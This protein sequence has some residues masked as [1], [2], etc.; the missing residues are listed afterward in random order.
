MT[1]RYGLPYMGSKSKIAR[2]VVERLPEGDTLYDV[3]C[4]RCAI[5]DYAMRARKYKSYVVN[6]ITNIG[7]VFKKA[8]EGGFKNETRWIDRKTYFEEL[9]D[10][11]V[12]LCFSFGNNPVCRYA[13]AV[14]LEPWKKA[15]HWCYVF[16]DPSLMHEYGVDIPVCDDK[17]GYRKWIRNNETYIR[18]R[19]C[20]WVNAHRAE[21]EEK[22]GLKIR[23][24]RLQSLG[25]LER[26]QRLESLDRLQRLQSLENPSSSLHIFQGDYRDVVIP[27]SSG[28]VY[29]D[30]PYHNTASYY[31][32]NRGKKQNL[33]KAF[34]YDGFYAWCEYQSYV[35][36]NPVFVSSYD[37]P[38]SKFRR[39]ASVEKGSSLHCGAV[40]Y[41]DKIEGLYVPKEQDCDLVDYVQVKL[42]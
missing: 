38:S 17:A 16:N 7:Y 15:L 25:S 21:I 40:Y 41:D 39:V 3:F 9:E 34:D 35:N 28:V 32:I 8:L 18:E 11:Y 27:K 10:P 37:L 13:Y 24:E 4:G 19:Y 42:F 30:P 14:E 23:L 36:R 5:T 1:D 31:E 22:S 26:L 12:Y 2:W 20:A 6:D 33:T 29:C